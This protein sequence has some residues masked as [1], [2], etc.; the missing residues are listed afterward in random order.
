MRNRWYTMVA[1]MLLVGGMILTAAPT[2]VG[3]VVFGQP[4]SV[5]TQMVYSSWTLEYLGFETKVSQF[6][7]PVSGFVPLRD[8]FEMSLFV[9][10]A[11]NKLDVAG[12]DFDLNGLGNAYV[13]ANHSFADDQLLVSLGLN[14]P[15]GKKKISFVTEEAVLQALALN[16]L[17]F[18]MRRL[19]EGF[20]FN[21]LVGGAVEL[22]EG[23]RGGG[24]ISYQFNGQ[25]QPY[26]DYGD[27][28][29]GDAITV[30]AGID[31]DQGS[32]VWTLDL[33]YTT[34]TDDKLDGEKTFKQSPQFTVRALGR[35]TGQTV[36]AS[37]TAM[38]LLRGENTE[39]T[40]TG[41]E[42]EAFKLYGDEIFLK[43]GL[44]WMFAERWYA[45]PSLSV[46]VIGGNDRGLEG[47]TVFGIG[48]GLSRLLSES[49]NA[50]GGLT[51]Y[52]GSADGGNID[53]TGLQV[54]FGLTASL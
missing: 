36:S 41:E 18:P 28:D 33:L 12:L 40:D 46:K 8:N 32:S 6:M 30:N 24:G 48:A 20:G 51:Y 29:P 2:A 50:G 4:T 21:M 26:E 43:G 54:T 1:G 17:D 34:F 5:G 44:D 7:M 19:G 15:T 14:L 37:G 3:Q 52:T 9:A 16:F 23:I 49:V 31:F 11:A 35:F 45:S 38:F 47:S 42:I 10:N 27:Y 13:Q 22:D 53:L 25:Y 39:Y